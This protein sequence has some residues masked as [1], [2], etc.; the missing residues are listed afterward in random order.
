M[1]YDAP[2]VEIEVVRYVTDYE[3]NRMAQLST[4]IDYPW[5]WSK[6]GCNGT[7]WFGPQPCKDLTND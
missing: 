2:P 5:W 6:H 4:K 7:R 1:M 3:L